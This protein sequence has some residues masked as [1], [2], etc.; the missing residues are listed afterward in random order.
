MM[1]FQEWLL[2]PSS[3]SILILG[4]ILTLGIP[5]IAIFNLLFGR[6]LNLKP[7]PRWITWTGLILWLVGLALIVFS[8]IFY[9][10]EFGGIWI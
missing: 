1:P 2:N 3:V 10:N 9:F 4:L 7:T 8:C 5:F 6:T